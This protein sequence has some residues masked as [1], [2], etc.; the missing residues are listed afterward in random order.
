MFRPITTFFR[1]NLVAK[2]YIYDIGFVMSVRL[3]V[4][5]EHLGSHWTDLHEIRYSSIF[6]KF[7]ENIQVTINSDKQNGYFT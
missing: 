3:S 7:V 2:E 1:E 5:T 4:R 6:R